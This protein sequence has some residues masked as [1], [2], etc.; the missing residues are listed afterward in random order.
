[1][2]L[3]PMRSWTVKKEQSHVLVIVPHEQ[4]ELDIISVIIFAFCDDE[5]QMTPE[6]NQPNMKYE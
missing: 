2:Y 4:I 6:N 3:C 5:Q 1:M